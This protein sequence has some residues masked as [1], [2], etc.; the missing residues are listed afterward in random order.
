MHPLADAER[1][2]RSDFA[3]QILCGCAALIVF[4]FL[5]LHPRLVIRKSFGRFSADIYYM[6]ALYRANLALLGA[7]VTAWLWEPAVTAALA[8]RQWQGTTTAR[9]WIAFCAVAFACLLCAVFIVHFGRWQFGGFDYNIIAETGW[10]QMLG[11]RPYVDFPTTSPPLFNLGTVIAF[12]LFGVSWDAMLFFTALFAV[13]TLVWL[14]PLFRRLG[15]GVLG[16]LGVACTLQSA[17]MLSCCFWWY[18][19]TTLLLAAVFFLSSSLLTR[20]PHDRLAQ[21]SFVVSM[22]LLA[23]AKPNIAGVTLVGCVGL[24]LVVSKQ[25]LRILM[26]CAAGIGLTLAIFLIAHISIPAMLAAYRGAAK[27]RG[28]FSSF[29]FDEFRQGEKRLVELWYTAL[30]LPLLSCVRPFLAR[31]RTDG[32]RAAAVWLF[33]PLSAVIA[34][35]GLRGNGE[36]RDVEATVL[37]SALGLLAFALHVQSP[38]TRRYTVALLCGM[39]A[40]DLYIGAARD[41]VYTIGPHFFFEWQDRDHLLTAGRFKHMRVSET[42]VE[43]DNEVQQAITTNPGPFFFGTRLDYSYMALGLPSPAGFPA[44]FHPGTAFDQAL[45]PQVLARWE[46]RR[47]P[48]LLYTKGGLGDAY[49]KYPEAFLRLLRTEY[50]RDDRYSRITVYHRRPGL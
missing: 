17:T 14:Y 50:I 3:W 44:W 2:G 28:A 43:V 32:L 42:F 21:S 48:T 33:F 35:Y 31:R 40:S 23:L 41:R 26:L 19:N 10:R 13:V 22:A 7:F 46:A 24:L 18:N 29:G 8:A 11:Q 47:F 27:E 36:L 39:A 37:V 30:C 6:R 5:F 45:L 1:T 34:I 15:M 16:S 9:R 20:T 49:Y 12:R 25:R 4:T 38:Q